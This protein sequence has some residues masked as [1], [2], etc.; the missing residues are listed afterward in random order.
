MRLGLLTVSMGTVLPTGV[1]TSEDGFEHTPLLP[2]H[3]SD[4]GGVSCVIIEFK[5]VSITS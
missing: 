2:I 3:S 1:T 4:C 5:S